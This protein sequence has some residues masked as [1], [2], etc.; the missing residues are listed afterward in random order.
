MVV[1]GCYE[2]FEGYPHRKDHEVGG[3]SCVSRQLTQEK[4]K[5]EK[6]GATILDMQLQAERRNLELDAL[7]YVWCSGGCPGG[8]HGYT[9]SRPVTEKLVQE[10]ERNTRRLREWWECHKW[11]EAQAAKEADDGKHKD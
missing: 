7:H 11:R 4:A 6:R 1:M 8:V 3:L 10:A 9:D 5:N 2:A